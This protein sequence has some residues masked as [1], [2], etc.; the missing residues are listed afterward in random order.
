MTYGYHDLE[1]GYMLSTLIDPWL[2]YPLITALKGPRYPLTWPRWNR[3]L[4]VMIKVT[5]GVAGEIAGEHDISKPITAQDQARFDHVIEVSRQIL[6]KAGCD[7]DTIFATPIRGTH[8]SA[9]IRIGEMLD[10]D[11]QTRVKNLYV[12]D[13]STFPRALGQPTVLTIICLAKRLSDHLL[14]NAISDRI[15]T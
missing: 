2:L 15:A 13:A 14:A 10:K 12:C 11:L 8:P 1:N 6:I 3:T 7:P 9:T 4:G 5:D